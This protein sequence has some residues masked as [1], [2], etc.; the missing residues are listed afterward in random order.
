MHIV[1]LSLRELIEMHHL[2]LSLDLEQGLTRGDEHKLVILIQ[3]KQPP[4]Q[5][6]FLSFRKLQMRCKCVGHLNAKE[7]ISR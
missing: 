3:V 4:E 2:P 6:E 5:Q 1:S 7:F